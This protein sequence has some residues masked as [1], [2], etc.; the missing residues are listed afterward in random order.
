M[1][2]VIVIFLIIATLLITVVYAGLD[3]KDGKV[4]NVATP[5]EGTDAANK[6]YVDAFIAP[7]NTPASMGAT[8][9]V[10]SI[11]WDNNNVYVCIG[12]NSWVLFELQAWGDTMI[13]EAG[14]TMLFEEGNTMIY[15]GE[16]L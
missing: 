8:G 6:D 5:T 11:V 4:V 16:P 12:N 13:D 1:K 15:D 3:A 7:G 9:T 10:G 2:R 14:D